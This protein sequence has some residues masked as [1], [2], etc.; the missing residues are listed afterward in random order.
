[1][2]VRSTVAAPVGNAQVIVV[3]GQRKSMT[4]DQ[5][6]VTGRMKI[7]LARRVDEQA[8]PSVTAVAHAGDLFAS[9]HDAPLGTASACAVGLPSQIDADLQKQIEANLTKIEIR[10]VDVPAT[11]DATVIVEVPPWPRL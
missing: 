2:V 8:P 4:A 10:C 11:G 3:D 9:A 1:V 6:R 7:A 5:L